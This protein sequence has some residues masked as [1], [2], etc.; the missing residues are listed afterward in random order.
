MKNGKLESNSKIVTTGRSNYPLFSWITIMP[1]TE[2]PFSFFSPSKS[3]SAM[4]R[5]FLYGTESVVS[6]KPSSENIR[7]VIVTLT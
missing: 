5:R 3:L 4:I 1:C 7:S 6:I 2:M